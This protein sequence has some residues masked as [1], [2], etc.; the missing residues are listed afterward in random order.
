MDPPKEMMVSD[1]TED[2]VTISWIKPMA[3]FEYYKLSYQSARG[4]IVF[5]QLNHF[6]SNCIPQR[7][8]T[9]LSYSSKW[10]WWVKHFL[11]KGSVF[12]ALCSSLIVAFYLWNLIE[13]V[14]RILSWFNDAKK[15]QV[16]SRAVPS[17]KKRGMNVTGGT[18]SD[19]PLFSPVVLQVES[20]AWW[21]TATC[22]TTPC[23][24][25]FLLRSMRSASMLSGGVRRAKWLA[26]PSSQVGA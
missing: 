22:P 19:V 11:G 16:L 5:T 15:R 9:S 17:T 1:V 24:A 10:I 2:S 23:R 8:P 18:S 26:P 25:C 4:S 21:L 12:T 13:F 7:H 6:G 3:P 14:I 20:T